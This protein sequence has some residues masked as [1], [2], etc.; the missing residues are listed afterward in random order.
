MQ[1]SQQNKV[2]H[3]INRDLFSAKKPTKND[4]KFEKQL[5]LF[6]SNNAS[7]TH[8]INVTEELKRNQFLKFIQFVC[9]YIG[10]ETTKCTV[11]LFATTH[12]ANLRNEN[13][14]GLCSFTD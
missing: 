9:N 8:V 7:Q 10:T 2:V 14:E 11:D 1:N 3:C 12:D 6:F 5:K 13:H 4:D